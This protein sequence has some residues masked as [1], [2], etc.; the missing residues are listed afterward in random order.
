MQVIPKICTGNTYTVYRYV[1]ITLFVTKV[2]CP[3]C[4]SV[5]GIHHRIIGKPHYQVNYE[6]GDTAVLMTEVESADYLSFDWSSDTSLQ[7]IETLVSL[8]VLKPSIV[9]SFRSAV[10]IIAADS[11]CEVLSN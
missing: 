10:M 4:R 2:V 6:E 9:E 7:V 5:A 3:C 11:V 8:A 1:V